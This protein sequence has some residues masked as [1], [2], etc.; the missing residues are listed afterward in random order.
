MFFILLLVIYKD[1]A[2]GKFISG[3]VNYSAWQLDNTNSYK[4][5]NLHKD[6]FDISTKGLLFNVSF[7][8]AFAFKIGNLLNWLLYKF[9]SSKSYASPTNENYVNLLPYNDK[10]FNFFIFIDTVYNK[11]LLRCSDSNDG[12]SGVIKPYMLVNW[13]MDPSIKVNFGIFILGSFANINEFMYKLWSYGKLQ[14]YKPSRCLNDEPST[15]N[16]YSFGKFNLQV[17]LLTFFNFTSFIYF[18]YFL[19][20]FY[21]FLIYS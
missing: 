16:I 15:L 9:K 21:Y 18:I 8:N 4:E 19:L 17:K 5:S 10:T 14:F 3:K 13:H 1:L 12:I 11:L 2:A 6:K 7:F 20:L